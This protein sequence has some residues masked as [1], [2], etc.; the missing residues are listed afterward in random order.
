MI[1]NDENKS[2]LNPSEQL[3]L[4][5]YN[6][7]FNLFKQLLTNNRIPKC[8]LLTGPKGIG[9]STFSY[10]LINYFFSLNEKNSYSLENNEINPENASFKLVNSNIHPNFY[11]LS[12][13][14]L[15]GDIKIEQV[16][17]L[18]KFLRNTTFNNNLKIVMIDNV[19]NLN[20]SSSNALLKCLEEKTDNTFFLLV[21]NESKNI[22]NT[23]KSRCVEFKFHLNETEK[24]NIFTKLSNQYFEDIDEK[25]IFDYFYF[26]TPG[27]LI[28]YMSLL[29][30]AE[31]EV[32]SNKFNAICFLID[33][34]IKE[35]KSETL[36]FLL[37]NIEKFYKDLFLSNS[38]KI[39]MFYHNKFKIIKLINDMKVYNLDK[40]NTFLGVKNIIQSDA[41]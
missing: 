10:H 19:E 18:L 6:L 24:Y 25:K 5:G 30:F 7:K 26:E 1:K 28:K 11:L 8:T 15:D 40:K 41:R 39:N 27:N 34:Y 9:K 16:R 33:I 37:T 38:N 14:N 3:R 23:I 17:N 35:E 21:H 4:Y 20:L 22:L 31:Y 13:Y 12:N 36:Y 32:L 2:I 29:D